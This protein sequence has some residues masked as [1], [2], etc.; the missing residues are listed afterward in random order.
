MSAAFK[1][2][3]KFCILSRIVCVTFAAARLLLLVQAVKLGT[4][5]TL[6]G[7]GYTSCGYPLP[8]E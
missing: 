8:A 7:N 2:M 5:L 3:T 6:L 4:S 1:S